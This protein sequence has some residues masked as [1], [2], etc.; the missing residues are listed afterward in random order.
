[1]EI[2]NN[3]LDRVTVLLIFFYVLSF[4]ISPIL[5]IWALNTLFQTG[6][7]M[8]LKNWLAGLVLMGIVKFL[9]KGKERVREMYED[10]YRDE[11]EPEDDP[12]W[13]YDYDFPEADKSRRKAK[14]ILY[15]N[16]KKNHT[17]PPEEN[18]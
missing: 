1:M 8:S 2:R 5:L 11:D 17:S 10:Y 7:A 6:I 16:P 12:D 4:L 14:L 13:E 9:L 3:E 18:S 15:Q